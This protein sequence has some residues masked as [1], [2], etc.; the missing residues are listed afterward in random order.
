MLSHSLLLTKV[1]P[2]TGFEA[3]CQVAGTVWVQS[4][5]CLRAGVEAVQNV[6]WL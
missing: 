6:P 2:L 1:A 5:Q 4:F 3:Q